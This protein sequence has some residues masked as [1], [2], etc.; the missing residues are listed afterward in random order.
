M[1]YG[2]ADPGKNT[3]ADYTLALAEDNAASMPRTAQQLYLQDHLQRV[4]NEIESTTRK[5]ELEKRRL[6]KLDEDVIRMRKEH[7]EKVLKI[8]PKGARGDAPKVGGRLEDQSRARAE[9]PPKTKPVDSN[10]PPIRKVPD[11]LSV[12]QLEHRLGKAISEFN[13]LCH[14]NQDLRGKIDQTRKERMQMNQVFKKVHGDI[15]ENSHSV[16]ML[17]RETDATRREYEERQSRMAALR[18]QLELERRTFKGLVQKLQRVMKER[19]R[20]ELTQKV[21]S[22]KTLRN[23]N[24]NDTDKNDDDKRSKT[25][26][27]SLK[28][29]E[30]ELFNSPGMMRR[31]LKLAFLNSIQRRHIKQHQK[32]IEVFEQAFATIKSTTGISDIEEI[33]KIFVQ[34]EQRNFSLLT[35]VNALNSEIESFDKQNRELEDQLSTQKK[36]E[37]ETDKKRS[38][39]LTDIIAQIENTETATSENAEQVKEQGR[40]FESCKGVIKNILATVEAENKV[41]GGQPAPETTGENVLGWLEYIEKTLTQWKDFLPETKDARHKQPSKNYKYTVGNQVLMLQ[42]KKHTTPQLVKP[43]ELPSAASAFMEHGTQPRGGIAGRDDE[44][45]DEED[46]MQNQAL[47][48][49]EL[50]E[51]ALQSV[52]KRK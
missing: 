4:H 36:V 38:T 41:F 8:K 31:I 44:S 40:V 18:K 21:Q 32:N 16:S 17:Q 15:K 23:G 47:K 19:E 11:S 5:L 24:A 51:R 37:Q 9:D 46:D 30:E 33:V 52:A 13:S 22:T 34:L 14:E 28:A 42:P 48:W 50:R 29:D 49:S 6:N 25:K 35:Y 20:E 39:A 27:K 2:K 7:E 10:G 43:A 3:S 12:R 45:S 26:T 1:A